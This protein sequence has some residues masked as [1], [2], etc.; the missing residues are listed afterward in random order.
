MAFRYGFQKRL[1]IDTIIY[2]DYNTFC[3]LCDFLSIQWFANT[4]NTHADVAELADAPDL[5]SGGRPWGFKSLHP[6]SQFSREALYL[7]AS[8]FFS[9]NIHRYLQF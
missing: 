2:F 5:G 3:A 4:Y 1:V 6:Q 8:R 7:Q 9:K